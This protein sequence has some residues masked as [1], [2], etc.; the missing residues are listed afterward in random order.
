MILSGERRETEEEWE[1]AENA[2][3]SINICEMTKC[4]CPAMIVFIPRASRQ[5]ERTRLVEYIRGGDTFH[6]VQRRQDSPS[7]VHP[8]QTQW[9]NEKDPSLLPSVR[10]INFCLPTISYRAY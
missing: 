10:S 4:V 1:K 7:Q 2:R 5:T 6:S 3:E 8:H 9:E